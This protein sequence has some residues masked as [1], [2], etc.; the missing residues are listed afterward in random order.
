MVFSQYSAVIKDDKL[1]PIQND[2]VILT[3]PSGL[4]GDFI[5]HKTG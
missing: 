2:S 4:R 5:R 1:I 3:I